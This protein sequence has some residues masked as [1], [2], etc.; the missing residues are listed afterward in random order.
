MTATSMV[1]RREMGIRG[2]NRGST[3]QIHSRMAAPITNSDHE[4]GVGK[5]RLMTPQHMA[6][7]AS[8]EDSTAP[9]TRLDTGSTTAGLVGK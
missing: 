4:W 9:S 2:A 5:M 7:L 3:N 8:M 1:S 6:T